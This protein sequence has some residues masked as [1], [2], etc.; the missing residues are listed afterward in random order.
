MAL[1]IAVIAAG[2]TSS[3]AQ[4]QEPS[5]SQLKPPAASIE[6][7]NILGGDAALPP[8]SDSAIDVNSP[9]RQGLFRKGLRFD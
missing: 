3:T 8:L 7:L 4:G 6:G 5:E 2:R 1:A 9:F